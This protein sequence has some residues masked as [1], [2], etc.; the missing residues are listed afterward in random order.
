MTTINTR[1]AWG[2]ANKDGTI[3]NLFVG[4]VGLGYLCRAPILNPTEPWAV[5][6]TFGERELVG[7]YETDTEARAALEQAARRAL[8]GG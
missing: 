4:R 2:A 1:L 5:F 6:L 8:E 3:D 7:R